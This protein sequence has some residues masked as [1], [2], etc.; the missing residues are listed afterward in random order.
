LSVI[1][2][3][4]DEIIAQPIVAEAMGFGLAV[5]SRY[6]RLYIVDRIAIRARLRVLE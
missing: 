3:R 5:D 4:S 1:D 6:G 2:A